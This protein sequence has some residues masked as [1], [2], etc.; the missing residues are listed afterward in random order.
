MKNTTYVLLWR[1]IQF[2]WMASFM[3]RTALLVISFSNAGLIASDLFFIYLKGFLFDTAVA[4]FFCMPYSLYLLVLP[5]KFNSSTAN[6]WI[7][8][9]GFFIIHI[10]I[11]FSFFAEFTFWEEFESRFNFIAV[12]YLIYTYE[13]VNNINQ[14]YPMP[15][16]VSAMILLTCGIMFLFYKLNFFQQSFTAVTILIKRLA[17]TLLIWVAGI[18]FIVFLSNSFAEN[19]LNRYRNELSKAGIFSFFSAYKNNELDYYSFYETKEEIKIFNILRNEL[20]ENGVEFSSSG[21]SIRRYIRQDNYPVQ[22]PNII[23][24]VIESFSADFMEHFGNSEGLTPYL[25]SLSEQSLFFTNLFATG[26]RTVRGMEALTLCVPP[27]PGSSIVRRPNNYNLFNIGTILKEQGYHSTFIY[28]GNGYFD[29]MNAFFGNNGFDMIDRGK[30]IDSDKFT[31]KRNTIPDSEV[32]FENAWGICDEDLYSAAIRDAD[33]KHASDVPFFQFIMTTSNHR[34][35]TFPAGKIDIPSGSGR[36]GAVKYTDFAIGKFFNMIQQKEWFNNTVVV[37]VADHCAS[38]AGKNEINVSKYHIPCIINNLKSEFSNRTID[39]QCSQIDI[40][41]TLFFLLGWQY[42]SNLFGQNVLNDN[43]TPRAFVGT[44]QK[45]G[46]LQQD[47][48]LIISPQ[49]HT[50]AC[51]LNAKKDEQTPIP[52]NDNLKE[53]AIAYYQTACYLFK[54]GKMKE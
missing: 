38:S 29:N 9:I 42:E 46:Y 21:N 7:T 53:K 51:L 36:A 39:K 18:L 28:G 43:F 37:I 23:L 12:D 11:M 25:D 2:F 13:V 4:V 3:V 22:K 16:L 24:I 54:N 34:P 19:S 15:L 40:L 1:F 17:I 14:S 26:T 27:T 35:Y 33:T 6:R 20:R 44:Y 47:T 49:Y 31:G 32:Y 50:E 30:S 52:M 10:I 8:Y 41:P 48:L 5:Q 45:L